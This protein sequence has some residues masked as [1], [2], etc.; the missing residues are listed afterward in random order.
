MPSTGQNLTLRTGALRELRGAE[1]LGAAAPLRVPWRRVCGA[2]SGAGVGGAAWEG[3][4]RAEEGAPCRRVGGC[5][6][7]G[8]RGINAEGEGWGLPRGG[9]RVRGT[10]ARPASILRAAT[11]REPCRRLGRLCIF[12]GS[13]GAARRDGAAARAGPSPAR[14]P[15]RGQSSSGERSPGRGPLR[16]RARLPPTGR[17]CLGGGAPPARH[18]SAG[19]PRQPQSL[20]RGGGAARRP[21]ARRARRAPRCAALRR[22]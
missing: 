15:S 20:P 17:S 4:A 1:G 13:S 19:G 12:K 10:G 3:P 11:G 8:H 14:A 18:A 6:A 16:R 7:R 9:G 2:A 22:R 5:R 21:R